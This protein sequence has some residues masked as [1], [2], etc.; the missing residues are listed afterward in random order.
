MMVIRSWL[1]RVVL[2]WG[3]FLV[4][5]VYGQ[6][7]YPVTFEVEVPFVLPSGV[8][9]YISGDHP[10]LGSWDPGLVN[11]HRV[12]P[13]R[14]RRTVWLPKGEVQFKF[15]LGSWR[16]VEK[17]VHW[18]E[19]SNRRLK[20]VGRG[21][22]F[23]RVARWNYSWDLRPVL[24]TWSGDIEA[25]A[26]VY[27][28]QLRNRRHIWV[29]LPPG[30][31]THLNRRYPVLYMHDG[32]NVFD[33]RR[34]FGGVE[35]SADETAKR[36][37][38]AQKVVGFIIVAVSN[39]AKRM[40]EYTPVRDVR[41]GGGGGEKYA[42]F[43]IK[44]LKPMIDRYYRTRPSREYTAVMGSSLG[45]LVSLYLVWRH[46]EVFSQAGVVSPSVW[47]ARRWVVDFVG[48]YSPRYPVRIWLDMGTQEG[49]DR[50]RDGVSDALEDARLLRD[51][52]LKRGM[53]YGKNFAYFEA[54]GA[55]HNEYFWAK[56]LGRIFRFLYG[57]KKN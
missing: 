53:R 1:G 54:V 7:E 35:W 10:R 21:S 30:Y 34:A 12:S 6:R 47:W 5:W 44:T 20:V 14:F 56:R 50:D 26:N 27:S 8:R 41:Y 3:C 17:G 2:L 46:S 48:R 25:I 22:Y 15:T 38:E 39:T 49:G 29:Y 28:P 45:G 23:F 24:P 13:R 51:V 31:F 16:H 33:A 40:Y 57:K 4:S 55:R 9:V 18:E 11:M 43:L 19:L 52:L 36:L 42:Q 37:L 32:N